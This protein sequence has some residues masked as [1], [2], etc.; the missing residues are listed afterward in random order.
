MV[1]TSKQFW[2]KPNF[3]ARNWT[4][5]CQSFRG[6]LP[7]CYDSFPPSIMASYFYWNDVMSTARIKLFVQ[8]QATGYTRRSNFLAMLSGSTGKLKVPNFDQQAAYFLKAKQQLQFQVATVITSQKDRH[9]DSKFELPYF[10][11][12]CSIKIHKERHVYMPSN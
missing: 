3:S 10:S 6:K 4:A 9:F 8:Y 11:P 2:T 5:K 1:T 7:Q 12:A